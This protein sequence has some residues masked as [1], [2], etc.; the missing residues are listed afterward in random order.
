[1][2]SATVQV[3][4]VFGQYVGGWYCVQNGKTFARFESQCLIP[5]IDTY[6]IEARTYLTTITTTF[7][8]SIYDE[9]DRG[10]HCRK[11]KKTKISSSVSSGRR[12]SQSLRVGDFGRFEAPFC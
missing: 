4:N 6:T 11:T 2:H 8:A 10:R 12:S 3:N 5:R 1:M 9:V 7:L